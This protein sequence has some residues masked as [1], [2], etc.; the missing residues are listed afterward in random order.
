LIFLFRILYGS[1]HT[2]VPQRGKAR[3]IA[4]FRFLANCLSDEL[5]LFLQLMFGPICSFFG[6]NFYSRYR[7]VRYTL[8]AKKGRL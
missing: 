2:H 5:Q 8:G 6:F 7:W 3:R 1:L 4:I